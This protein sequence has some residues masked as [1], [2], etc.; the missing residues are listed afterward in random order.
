MKNKSEVEMDRLLET[1]VKWDMIILADKETAQELAEYANS[2][3]YTSE[4]FVYRRR[5]HVRLERKASD[6]PRLDGS[7]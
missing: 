7:E 4:Y 6:Y 5:P 3:G 2:K 1:L